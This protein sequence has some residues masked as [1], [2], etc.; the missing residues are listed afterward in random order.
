M[1]IEGVPCTSCSL[2]CDD[3]VVDVRDNT[4]TRV[5]GTCSHG[6]KRFKELVGARPMKVA[7]AEQGG[8]KEVSVDE[9]L[10]K[11]AEILKV[12]KKPLIYGGA[13]STNRTVELLVKLAQKLRGLYDSSASICHALLDLDP[14]FLG[15][16]LDDILEDA[17]F[18]LYWGADP[19]ET[20]LRHASRYAVFP[21]GR[22]T[23]MGRESRIVAVVDVRETNTMRI[24]QHKVLLRPGSDAELA[25]ALR[26]LMFSKTPT[27]GEAAGVT[28][29]D[30]SSII[31][32]LKPA[33]YVAMF[34]GRGLLQSEKPEEA[35][36]SM[37]EL[38]RSLLELGKKVSIMPMAEYVNSMGQAL[39]TK[40]LGGAPR[41]LDFSALKE[42]MS[43]EATATCQLER[44]GVDAALIVKSEVSEELTPLAVK[45]L[46]RIPTIVLEERATWTF[47]NGK[48]SVPLSIMGVE[49]GG[50]V[51]RMDGVEV[52][53]KPFLKPPA[54]VADE[55]V[56]LER[57]SSSL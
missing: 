9:A 35:L 46:M 36:S 50:T 14:S 27:V 47:S 17:D 33:T 52:K 51:T 19:A 5:L 41:A 39:I 16:R 43:P 11:A 15:A 34:I 2:L 24:A 12:A 55:E 1:E 29:R 21:R 48:V 53:L 8:L 22:S 18:I 10:E 25:R 44:E 28:L 31:K 45:A 23:P 4:V 54:S 57:L 7:I 13:N 3:I 56:F 30:L 20:H 32:D 49:S 37:A 6:T 40:K 26:D 38:A 42:H